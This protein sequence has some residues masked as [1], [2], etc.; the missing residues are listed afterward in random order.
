MF[1]SISTVFFSSA[2]VNSS[3]PVLQNVAPTHAPDIMIF[4]DTITLVFEELAQNG[5]VSS[6]PI[7][8]IEAG[9]DHSLPNL[10]L[11]LFYG[12]NILMFVITLYH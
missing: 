5:S 4:I 12:I 1:F 11:R 8:C 9:N 3:L 10:V 7:S 2:F 6:L